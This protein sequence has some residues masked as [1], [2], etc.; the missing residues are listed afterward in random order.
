MQQPIMQIMQMHQQHQQTSGQKQR[1]HHQRYSN[2]S[3][4]PGNCNPN[5][6]G[7]FSDDSSRLMMVSDELTAGVYG[8]PSSSQQRCASRDASRGRS[9][10]QNPQN[11]HP[12]FTKNKSSP[13]KIFRQYQPNQASRSPFRLNEGSIRDQSDAGTSISATGKTGA[14][15]ISGGHLIN[16]SPMKQSLSKYCNEKTG[17]SAGKTMGYGMNSS[18]GGS[19][20][21]NVHQR[22]REYQ[23]S[24]GKTSVS[25]ALFQQKDGPLEKGTG[26]PSKLQQKTASAFGQSLRF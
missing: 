25:K 13:S 9:S 3:A 6:S 20:I 11:G 17:P 15:A 23:G 19:S 16:V 8:D 24:H 22:L 1:Y 4:G 21:Q 18:N 10:I 14:P 5:S 26:S 2:L 7:I 12:A